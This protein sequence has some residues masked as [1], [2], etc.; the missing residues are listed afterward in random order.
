MSTLHDHLRVRKRCARRTSLLLTNNDRV[1]ISGVGVHAA[2]VQWRPFKIAVQSANMWRNLDL[3][4]WSGNQDEVGGPAV[5][6]WVHTPQTQKITQYTEDTGRPILWKIGP[7]RRHCSWGQTDRL[8]GLVQAP[9]SPESL[10]QFVS[11]PPTDG[12]PWL[13]LHP[14]NARCT[15]RQQRF[16]F[17]MRA[18]CSCYRTHRT[19]QTSLPAASSYSQKWENNWR[20][21]CSSAALN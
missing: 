2:E 4:M 7:C 14:D 19:H 15:Q 11:A 9:P 21:L 6:Q 17:S 3:A 1:G 12:T 20:V 16:T 18:R 5:S 13:S 10:G 8:C